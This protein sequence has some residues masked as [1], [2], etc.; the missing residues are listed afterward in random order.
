MLRLCY[1]GWEIAEVAKANGVDWFVG[2][3]M[4]TAN[5]TN[6]RNDN[7]GADTPYAILSPEW[8]ALGLA[9]QVKQE[10]EFMD[11]V[12]TAEGGKF[13]ELSAARNA[14]DTDRFYE[15]VIAFDKA[16]M[17]EHGDEDYSKYIITPETIEEQKKAEQEAW[18]EFRKEQEGQGST[19]GGAEGP[20][21]AGDEAAEGDGAQ[22]AEEAAD[23]G[24]EV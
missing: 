11:M 21:E 3:E 19:E 16:W 13:K 10:A 15:I 24:Q 1:Y 14:G 22:E 18:E 9:K 20:S 6:G 8:N 7:K 5:L 23:G 17:A 12:G 4:F 2:K